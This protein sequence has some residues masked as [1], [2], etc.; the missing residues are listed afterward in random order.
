MIVFCCCSRGFCNSV[1]F[2]IGVAVVVVGFGAI[3]KAAGIWVVAGN[4]FVALSLVFFLIR[5]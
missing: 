5:Q 1:G 3:A 2:A 4:S